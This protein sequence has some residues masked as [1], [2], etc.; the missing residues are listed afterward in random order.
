MQKILQIQKKKNALCLAC[1]TF[2]TDE[3][4]EHTSHAMQL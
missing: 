4:R 2:S 3:M 1:V